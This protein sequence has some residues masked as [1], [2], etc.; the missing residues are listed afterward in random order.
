[1]KVGDSVL[2][3]SNI[4]NLPMWIGGI[5][6]DVENNPFR[7]IVISAQTMDGNVFLA[8]KTTLTHIAATLP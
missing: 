6:I 3:S 4:T 5:I 8:L 2:I 7:E 1:M